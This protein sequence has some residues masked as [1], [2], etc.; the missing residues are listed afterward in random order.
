[1]SNTTW[2][3]AE[4]VRREPGRTLWRV[5]A[6]RAGIKGEV[7]EEWR[8]PSEDDEATGLESRGG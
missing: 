3:T 6:W 8:E 2:A 4:V 7:R 1:M 5:T